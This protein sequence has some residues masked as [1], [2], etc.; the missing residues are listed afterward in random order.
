MQARSELACWA[1]GGSGRYSAGEMVA[2]GASA[3][4]EFKADVL[5]GWLG[6]E[7][8]DSKSK[9]GGYFG[10][11]QQHATDAALDQFSKGGTRWLI[12]AAFNLG[13]LGGAV[14]EG[15]WIEGSYGAANGSV[16][17][18]NDKVAL[19]SLSFGPPSLGSTFQQAPPPTN[20]SNAAGSGQSTSGA[21]HG[22][23]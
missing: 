15:L 16:T 10:Y 20:G 5:E 3:T 1:F 9:F 6:L 2:T 13:G 12:S 14:P 4:P 18:L 8:I 7:R 17:T 19:L 11:L 21:S 23:Q 22:S